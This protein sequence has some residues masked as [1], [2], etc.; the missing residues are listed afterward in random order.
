VTLPASTFAS[1]TD[2]VT[3]AMWVNGGDTKSWGSSFYAKDASGKIILGI[4]LP[5]T[6]GAV[7]WDVGR[8]R[9]GCDRISKPAPTDNYKGVWNHWV[10]TKNAKTGVMNIYYNGELFETGT[11]KLSALGTF[12]KASISGGDGSIDNVRVYKAA[13]SAAEVKELYL[14]EK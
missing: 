12:S 7:L 2:Q 1:I 6:S 9:R 13:L 3:I 11:R 4:S 14:K 10:F 5:Y 8:G